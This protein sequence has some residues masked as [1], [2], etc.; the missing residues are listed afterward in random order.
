M[1]YDLVYLAKPVYGG[2]VTFTAHLLYLL[3]S[4][5]NSVRL[6]KAKEDTKNNTKYDYGYGITYWNIN[7]SQLRKLENPIIT[8]VDKNNYDFLPFL[9]GAYLVIHDPTE[10]SE[11]LLKILNKFK[12]I[13]IRKTVHDL[14]ATKYGIGSQLIAHPFYNRHAEAEA[15]TDEAVSIS[16]VDFDK[17]TE[18]ILEANKLL[19]KPIM[20]YGNVNRLYEHFR[21]EAL[22]FR[23][24]YSGSF[25]KRFEDVDRILSPSKYMVDMSAIKGDGGGTQYTFLEAIANDCVVVLNKKWFVNGENEMKDG[26]NCVSASNAEELAEI[27]K[28]KDSFESIRKEA[29]EILRRHDNI[30]IL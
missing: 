22:D 12:I 2:W 7:K 18:I 23:K 14:L 10:L 28:S 26:I 9:F 21:L 16:R 27:I 4:K 30:E 29:K 25:G 5:G 6:F 1:K 13:T 15:K 20:I 17:H 8:A 19:E 3:K 24:Y 11:E